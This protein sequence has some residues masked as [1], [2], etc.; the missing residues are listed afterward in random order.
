[1]G[2]NVL[3]KHYSCTNSLNSQQ[4]GTTTKCFKMIKII[5]LFHIL[6]YILKQLTYKQ[7][8]NKKQLLSRQC[9]VTMCCQSTDGE[10][11]S[12]VRAGHTHT[13]EI[14]LTCAH[15]PP[16][17]TDVTLAPKAHSLTETFSDYER[18]ISENDEEQ[19]LLAQQFDLAPVLC[20]INGMMVVVVGGLSCE[21]LA[22]PCALPF[23]ILLCFTSV[24]PTLCCGAPCMYSIC[25]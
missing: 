5:I 20:G 13:Q 21:C 2:H 3:V 25:M 16:H 18:T 14:S 22:M 10:D 15:T 24:H 9:A 12:K 17:L 1:M 7:K 23:Y 4:T 8:H 19:L 11:R 6:T